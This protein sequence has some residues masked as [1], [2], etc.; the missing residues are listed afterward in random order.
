MRKKRNP[1]RRAKA[2][3]RRHGAEIGLDYARLA[4]AILLALA[5]LV[6]VCVIPGAAWIALFSAVPTILATLWAKKT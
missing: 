1:K 6:A 4:P 5:V 2:Q 3:P